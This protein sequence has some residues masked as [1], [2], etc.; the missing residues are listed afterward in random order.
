MK[1]PTDMPEEVE[2][3]DRAID[4]EL[5]RILEE[6]PIVYDPAGM[7]RAGAFVS[8]DHD[9]TLYIER[10][11]RP[12]RGRGAVGCGKIG[13]MAGR[14]SAGISYGPQRPDSPAQGAVVSHLARTS[15]RMRT[16]SSGRC[17][18]G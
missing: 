12:A 2:A 6:R 16:T 11:F 7:A 17:R 3:G 10:G 4:E 5:A 8:L 14:D 9:G 1:M 18:I 13:P 15:A